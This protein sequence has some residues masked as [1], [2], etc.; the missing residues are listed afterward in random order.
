MMLA[1]SSTRGC[2]SASVF[3]QRHFRLQSMLHMALSNYDTEN[4]EMMIRIL[5]CDSLEY[6]H[7]V[8]AHDLIDRLDVMSPFP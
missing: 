7:E 8:S 5:S 1:D 3:G 4:W 2:S 6:T